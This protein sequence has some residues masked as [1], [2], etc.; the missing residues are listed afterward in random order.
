MGYLPNLLGPGT[1]QNR[2]GMM[3]GAAAGFFASPTGDSPFLLPL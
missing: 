1:P 2:I 3:T